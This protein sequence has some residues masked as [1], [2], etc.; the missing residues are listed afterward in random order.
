M[1]NSRLNIGILAHVDAGK[2][3]LSEQLLFQSGALRTAGSVDKG[4][5]ITD[6]LDV[7]RERGI[8]V[9]LSTASLLYE[10]T[11][12]NI[13]D[14]PGHID[15]SAE[16][17]Y[18]LRAMDAVILLISALEGVQ[19]HTI[20]LFNAI[21]AMKKPCMIFINKIDRTGVEIDQVM[22]DIKQHLTEDVVLLQ[23]A[24]SAGSSNA[25]I[26][27]ADI[28]DEA[29]M[30][31]ILNVDDVL[32]ERYL[33]DEML[34]ENEL[35]ESLKQSASQG[36]LLP[37]M[38]GAAKN[39]MGVIPL[40]ENLLCFFHQKYQESKP[41]SALAFKV[42]HHKTLGKM[43]YVRVFNGCINTR[44]ILTKA[45]DHSVK[46]SQ[47]VGQLKMMERGK[48]RDVNVIPAGDI[49]I[50]IGLSDARVGDVYGELTDIPEKISLSS[51]LLTV[52]VIPQNDHDI[53][54]VVE[55]MYQLSD[56]DPALDV[57]WLAEIR[58]LHVKVTG[59]IQIEILQAL[60]K[61]RYGLIVEFSEPSIIYKETPA[62]LVYG[63]ERYWMPKPCWAIVKFKIEPAA[64]GAGVI[65]ESQVSVNDVA[66]K[67]Q[68]EIV[69][70]LD[71]ALVQGI[72]GWQVT[73]LK[74]TLVEGED[75][76]VHSR[77]GDF[78]T[79]TPM[80]IMNGLLEAG[81]LLLEP[82]LSFQISADIDLLG[83]ITSD[84]IKMRGSYDSP[85]IVKGAFLLNGKVPAATSMNY[86]IT[87]AS[88]SAGKAKFN[89]QLCNYEPCSDEQGKIIDYRGVC[90]LDRDKWILQ[91]R[92]AL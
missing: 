30:E 51:P 56:E 11:K 59:L 57:Q 60:I 6:G 66:T 82:I 18:S 76:N 43:T 58:E 74:I 23:R 25:N 44:D 91:A 24:Y 41:I 49:G 92:G 85:E 83:T 42:E 21:K 71:R 15:F 29:V 68:K 88:I 16:V 1:I 13:I 8:S 46:H 84:I 27:S 50:V 69:E 67:Y 86:P 17:E 10:G 12:I 38:M 54:A 55:V 28:M 62:K 65:Y 40:L 87:L 31:T 2:T 7:E 4:T 33:A 79:A 47:K 22:H 63:F 61:D 45:N 72:K 90:P 35:I 75:H 89:A 80:A 64:R 32:M 52:Q 3:T 70:T 78:A 39:G 36:L 20:T 48:L 81:T 5:S 73:D 14:T 77:S 34:T 19:G 9:R 53:M 26:E 37:I